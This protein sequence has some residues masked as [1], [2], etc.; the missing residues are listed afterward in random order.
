MLAAEGLF[1]E[2]FLRDVAWAA[3]KYG[4]LALAVSL[5]VV[6]VVSLRAMR[7]RKRAYGLGSRR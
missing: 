2:G 7:L 3:A 1:R 6:L 4:A 5:V